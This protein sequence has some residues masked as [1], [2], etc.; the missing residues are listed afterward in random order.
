M[1][2]WTLMLSSTLSI[3]SF[4][5]QSAVEVDMLEQPRRG[6]FCA[7]C[8]N[9]TEKFLF[10]E[11]SRMVAHVWA[12]W[13]SVSSSPEQRNFRNSLW[14][15]LLLLLLVLVFLLFIIIVF[16]VIIISL[17][18]ICGNILGSHAELG[19]K[20]SY[21]LFWFV[22]CKE[23]AGENKYRERGSSFGCKCVAMKI[24]LFLFF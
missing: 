23:H 11:G 20:N 9:D 7:I 1:I 6:D 21:L 2:T 5:L 8:H 12:P 17:F 3:T 10:W 15:F 18:D 16:C 22:I 14:G 24:I 4:K 19:D 13:N